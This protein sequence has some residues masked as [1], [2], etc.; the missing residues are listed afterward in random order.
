MII[1]SIRAENVLKYSVLEIEDIPSA[2]LIAVTGDN[3]SGK[4]SI[5]ES[6]CFALFGRTFSLGPEELDKVIRWGESRCSIRL[7]FT[8]PDGLRYQIARFL[9]EKGNHGASI[10]FTGDEPMVR[11]LEEV[12]KRL[13]TIIG[14]GYTEFI[15]SFYLAQREISTPNPHSFAVKAMAGVDAMERATAACRDE[16]DRLGD[17]FNETRGEKSQIDARITELNLLDG[18]LASLESKHRETKVRLERENHDIKTADHHAGVIA[19]T[20]AKLSTAARSGRPS[21]SPSAVPESVRRAPARGRPGPP[22]RLIPG[23]RRSW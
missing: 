23:L 14:F 22:R 16:Q 15:E 4:S 20:T 11:G 7:E 19:D 13:K 17:Q 9:D 1:N 3:E 8:T 10:S 12:E 18:Y 21:A 5:G 6:I 2:G